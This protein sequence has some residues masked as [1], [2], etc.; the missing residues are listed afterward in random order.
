M[1]Q[2][3]LKPDFLEPGKAISSGVGTGKGQTEILGCLIKVCLGEHGN[4]SIFEV[5][6]GWAGGKQRKGLIRV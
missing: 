5:E 1:I 4:S 6:H 3:V 2:V